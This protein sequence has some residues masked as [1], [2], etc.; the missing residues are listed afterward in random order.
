MYIKPKLDQRLKLMMEE[1]ENKLWSTVSTIDLVTV[2]R[3][4]LCRPHL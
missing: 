4:Y 1:I 2:R 3:N